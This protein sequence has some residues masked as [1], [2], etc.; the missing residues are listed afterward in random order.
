MAAEW[1]HFKENR[2]SFHFLVRILID[3]LQRNLDAAELCAVILSESSDDENIY[4]NVF[5]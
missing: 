2:S 4:N 3:V 5:D 1:H